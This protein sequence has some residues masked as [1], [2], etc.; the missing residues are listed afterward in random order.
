MSFKKDEISLSEIDLLNINID[1]NKY[2]NFDNYNFLVSDWSGI[3]I[4]YSLI[5]MKKSYLINT[6]KKDKKEKY[7]K[8]LNIPIEINMRNI[9]G[10]TFE[11]N[12]IEE[13]VEKIL[14]LKNNNHVDIKNEQL[15][16]IKQNK[17]Y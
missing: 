13:L 16:K 2:I 15:V 4:E 11:V 12:Q 1:K 7:K 8:F 10:N 3:F 14:I 5:S 6:P 17:F 9:F